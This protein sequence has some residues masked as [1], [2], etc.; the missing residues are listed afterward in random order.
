MTQTVFEAVILDGDTPLFRAAKSLE[1]DYV[2]VTNKETGKSIPVKTQKEFYGQAKE[3]EG[4]KLAEINARHK[5]NYKWDDFTYERKSKLRPYIKKGQHVEK[6]LEYFSNFI[7]SLHDWNLSDDLVIA[8]GGE[9][10]HRHDL[11]H[12]TKYKGE[13]PPKPILFNEVREAIIERYKNIIHVCDGYEA[14]D[15]LSIK[16]YESFQ[17]YKETGVWKYVLAY[18]DKDIKMAI[19]PSINFL[20]KEDGLKFNTPHEAAKC[21]ASQLLTGDKTVDN[22]TGLPDLVPELRTKYGLRK[23]KGIGAATAKNLLEGCSTVEM[24][25]R[26]VEAYRAYYGD[27]H[28][29]TS[30]RGEEKVYSWLD[31]L[32]ET[33]HLIW[34]QRHHDE[35]IDM[36]EFLNKIGVNYE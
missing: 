33:A 34:M 23:G 28:R 7:G 3:K 21:F 1:E 4:G 35:I 36:R 6:A 16:G 18:V 26:V 12:L 30:W 15:F 29:F 27:E 8:I 24:F 11:A 20:K 10:C 31:H 9:P 19:C 2:L 25:E 13:R 22:I 32:Q 14:D 5:T 17:Q